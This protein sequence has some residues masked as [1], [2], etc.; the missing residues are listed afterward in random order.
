MRETEWDGSR[1]WDHETDG[2]FY[3][4]SLF[5]IYCGM[6]EEDVNDGCTDD[7]DGCCA[8]DTR[9]C[10]RGGCDMCE[11]YPF[12]EAEAEAYNRE[13]EEERLGRPLFPNEY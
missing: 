7:C 13:Y 4:G 8:S 1:E 11:P 3:Q 9:A 10:H 6:T 5:C 12:W 2:C